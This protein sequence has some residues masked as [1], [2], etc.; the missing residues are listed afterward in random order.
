M[1]TKID[2]SKNMATQN[3]NFP[4]LA[5]SNRH[6]AAH[7]FLD[8][9][10][11]V[12]QAHPA[13]LILREKDLPAEDYKTLAI[14]VLP[15]CQ[16]YNVSCILH[17]FWQDAL[18]LGCTCIHL[19]LPLLR[20]LAGADGTA[21]EKLAGFSVIGTSVHSVDGL[22]ATSFRKPFVRSRSGTALPS[23]KALPTSLS[24]WLAKTPFFSI[25]N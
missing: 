19:P 1:N 16:Q 15:I 7:P 10:E 9:I 5:V 4:I 18:A 24:N 3:S 8:Q 20:S 6:L 21:L 22:N 11:R 2:I 25:A 13:A 12:C 14:R 23:P 17:T